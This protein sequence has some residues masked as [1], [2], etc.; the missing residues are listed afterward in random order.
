MSDPSNEPDIATLTELL[1]RGVETAFPR[2][3]S[4]AQS[5]H[6]AAQLLLAQMYI[7][8]K[9][10]E[11]D[12][13]SA[14]HWYAVAASHGN[15]M[16]MN[17]AG[18]CH[19][20]GT[21]TTANMELA[22]VWYRQAAEAKLDWGMYN[23]ANML[24]TGRG[25]KQD[26]SKALE[27]YTQAAHMGHAKSM[28]LLARHLEEGWEVPSDPEAALYWY[29]KSAESGDFRGQASYA[30]I[31]MHAGAVDEASRWLRLA[32]SQGSASF[33]SHII[34]VLAS[35]PHDQ[36]RALAAEYASA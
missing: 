16:A 29:K 23:Y 24:A 34:P 6:D 8:G 4:L 5:G 36:I 28:N 10:V 26:P 11:A 7:E 3:L 32:L 31:L 21:G 15:A 1:Q 19:E 30:S 33:M 14:M 17:M 12:P 22:A 35:S 9:G 20:L 13:E 27:L 18:R 25:V 2:I